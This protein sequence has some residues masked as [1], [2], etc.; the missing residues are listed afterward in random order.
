MAG[1]IKL[2]VEPASHVKIDINKIRKGRDKKW[3]NNYK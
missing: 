2:I 3:I 1:R